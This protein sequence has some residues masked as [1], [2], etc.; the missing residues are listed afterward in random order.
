MLLS[1]AYSFLYLKLNKLKID[2]IYPMSPEFTLE[3]DKFTEYL[4]RWFWKLFLRKRVRWVRWDKKTRK[5]FF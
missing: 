5:P 4:Y 3:K 2:Q 1:T